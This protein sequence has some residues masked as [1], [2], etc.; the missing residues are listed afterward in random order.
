MS[1]PC[2]AV[3]VGSNSVRVLVLDADGHRV[4]RL[5]SITRLGEGVDE[6]G[7]L[8]GEAL[9]RTMHVLARYRGVWEDAGVTDRVRIAATSAV[10]DAANA[11]E[12]FQRVRDTTGVEAEVLSG[13]DEARLAFAGA[14][15]GIEPDGATTL[16]DVGGGSTEIVVGD[17]EGAVTAS[18]SL[19]LGCVRLAERAV[20]SD[21]VD[22]VDVKAGVR[23][24]EE[25]LDHADT[26]LAPAT[27]R[28]T[29]LVG[30]AGTVTTIAALHLGLESYE[31]DRIHGTFVH[32]ADWHRWTNRLLQMTRAERAM[33]GPMAP[34]REDVI[35]AGAMIV[36]RFLV[37]HHLNG[38]IASEADILDGLAASL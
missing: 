20:H 13:H 33:L 2:A 27:P 16:I 32:A 4:T 7:R 6:S 35:Q 17:A 21:P 1:V 14:I 5:M 9:D 22:L 37:R 36:D 11:D 23:I 18:V 29:R 28:G 24:I 34:G 19:Q 12:F 15:G 3:D 30:V 25:Q 31:E 10:R 38:I 26:L 8:K